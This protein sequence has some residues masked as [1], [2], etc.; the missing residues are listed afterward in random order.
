MK[1]LRSKTQETNIKQTDERRYKMNSM[2]VERVKKQFTEGTKVYLH[3]MY[4]EPQMHD[5][6]GEV[7]GV[8]DIG[9]V[10]MKWENGSTLA[11][12]VESDIFEI[13]R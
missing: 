10:H 11:L 9:Q 4:G 7:I 5:L 13:V 12:N 3:G 1:V 2:Q 8:D 6:Y